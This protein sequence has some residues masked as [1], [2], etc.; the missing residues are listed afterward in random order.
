MNVEAKDIKTLRE[1]TGVSLGKCKEALVTAGGD[2]EKAR[3]VLKEFSRAAAAKKAD[4]ELGA[5]AIVSY[6]HA[7]AQMGSLIEGNCETDF[8]A[9]NEEFVQLL[10]DIAMHATAMGSSLETIMQEPFIKNPETTIEGLI[11]EHVQK[12]GERI[13][14]SRLARFSVLD[15]A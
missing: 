2:I 7:N 15:E 9:R 12:L 1:E 11:E 10:H 6:V 8:V 5:G 4:R 14:V 13:E 3:E